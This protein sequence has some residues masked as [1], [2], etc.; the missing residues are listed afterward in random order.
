MIPLRDNIEAERRVW[1]NWALIALNVAVFLYELSLGPLLPAFFQDHGLVPARVLNAHA[2]SMSFEHQLGPLVLHMFLHGG[3]LHLIGN[4]WFLHIFG[5]N[6]E[7]RLGHLDYLLFYL[8]CG[9]AAAAGQVLSGPESFTPMIGASGAV[10][11][12]LGAY[13]VLFPRARVLTLVPIFIFIQFLELPAVVFLG[14][15]GLMQF[16]RGTADLVGAGGG[17]T[18]GVAWWAHVAGFVAGAGFMWARPG[19]RRP[20]PRW[21][22][23]Y[24]R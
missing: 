2:W 15:W 17:A 8:G 22:Q 14:F 5:D 19:L 10:A 20:V 7:G 12:V 24:S 9:F 16:F 21:R 13:L 11:G 23:R 1:V 6:I 3:W 18:D 4:M